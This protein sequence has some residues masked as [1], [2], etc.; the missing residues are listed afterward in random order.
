MTKEG[1]LICLCNIFSF[2]LVIPLDYAKAG[3][4]V[5]NGGDVVLCSAPQGAA[6]DDSPDSGL[7]ALDYLLVSRPDDLYQPKSL[8]DA[9]DHV[10]EA[11]AGA[12]VLLKSFRSYRNLIGNSS[13]TKGIRIWEIN[14]RRP[15]ELDDE[16]LTRELPENCRAKK[17]TDA[18]KQD[19]LHLGIYQAIIRRTEG[20]YIYYEAYKPILDKLE[21]PNADPLQ[22]SMLYVHEWLWDYAK[23]A[24]QLRKLNMLLHQ[25]NFLMPGDLEKIFLGFGIGQDGGQKP[26]ENTA[27]KLGKPNVRTHVRYHCD[28]IDN[29]RIQLMDSTGKMIADKNILMGNEAKC[30]EHVELFG[31]N[32]LQP[33][34][35]QKSV[36][37]CDT[38]NDLTI[39]TI[40][41]S[42]K[43]VKVQDELMKNWDQCW[44]AALDLNKVFS[45]RT[46][47]NK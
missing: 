40:A 13:L 21:D 24:Y 42:G 27:E 25:Q 2:V 3:D 4:F 28:I 17:N 45:S 20:R 29:L 37:V 11:L 38:I 32:K 34:D 9:L 33:I 10:E 44:M 19:G 31:G 1:A 8:E 30:K 12:P 22:A 35:R 41:P 15:R 36:A 6:I 18:V 5:G 23:N 14:N 43:I 46:Q 39:F 16:D 7:Y 47:L 26:R